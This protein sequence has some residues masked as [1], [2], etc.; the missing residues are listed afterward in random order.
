[1]KGRTLVVWSGCRRSVVEHEADTIVFPPRE[2][3]WQKCGSFAALLRG[4][5]LRLLP[6]FPRK[7]EQ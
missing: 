4:D 6:V 2:A 7:A 5:M 3:A 1:M